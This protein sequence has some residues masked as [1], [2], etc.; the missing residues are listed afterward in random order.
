MS[1]KSSVNPFLRWLVIIVLGLSA[2]MTLL[3]GI[4]TSCVALAP[5]NWGPKMAPL[6]QVQGLFI[7]LVIVSVLAGLLGVYNLFHLVKH[8]T[9]LAYR[10]IWIFLLVGG[11]A[12]AVQYYFSLTLRGATAPN[13]V[14]LYLTVFAILLLLVFRLPRLRGKL[15]FDA[16]GSGSDPA[17]G[18]LA[19]IVFGLVTLSTPAWAE[20]SH[21]LGGINTTNVLFWPLVLGGTGLILGG[22]LQIAWGRV[23][24]ALELGEPVVY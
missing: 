9:R 11:V 3:G 13:N 12:S 6:A 1:G 23:W 18:G 14:R 17:R 8:G 4:G 19:M 10:N 5:L 7:I 16:G 2:L 21:M 15:G 20:S 22:W 24:G